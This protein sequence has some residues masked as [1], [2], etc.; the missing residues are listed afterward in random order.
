MS[1][2]KGKIVEKIEDLNQVQAS[3]RHSLHDLDDRKKEYSK[4]KYEKLK[5]KYHKK[6]EKIRNKIHI[7]EGKLVKMS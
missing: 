2:K 1:E 7:L 5:D 6:M 4:E 3:L